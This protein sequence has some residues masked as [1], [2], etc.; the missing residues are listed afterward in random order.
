MAVPHGGAATRPKKRDTDKKQRSFLSDLPGGSTHSTGERLRSWV[1][2]N[3]T[4]IPLR[5]KD[6]GTKLEALFGAYTSANPPVHQKS[7]G[8]NKFRAAAECSVPRNRA[9]QERIEH[10]DRLVPPPLRKETSEAFFSE[11]VSAVTIACSSAVF[12][13]ERS[14]T[15]ETSET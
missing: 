7:L 8:R 4:H 1:E 12:F 15:R 11:K 5:E 9:A 2:A 13:L 10:R 3:Y 14:G 6:T